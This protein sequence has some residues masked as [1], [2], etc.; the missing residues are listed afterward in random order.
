MA[1]VKLIVVILLIGSVAAL[2][3]AGS[4][5]GGSKMVTVPVDDSSYL[6]CGSV[7]IENNWYSSSGGV[8]GF[9][10]G[11]QV[12]ESYLKGIEAALLGKFVNETGNEDS[13]IFYVETDENGYFKRLYRSIRLNSNAPHSI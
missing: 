13:K 4:G 8:G 2:N 11:R 5:I 6:V 7:I 1:K 12:E 3:C 9:S 10:E